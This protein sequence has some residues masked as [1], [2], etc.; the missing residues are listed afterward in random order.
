MPVIGQYWNHIEQFTSAQGD[1]TI[2]HGLTN[3]GLTRTPNFHVVQVVTGAGGGAILGM[4][5]PTGVA[6]SADGTYWRFQSSNPA[7]Q[8]Y[9]VDIAFLNSIVT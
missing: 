7:N 1:N 2:P 3:R 6:N 8:T 4:S 9:T 5:P